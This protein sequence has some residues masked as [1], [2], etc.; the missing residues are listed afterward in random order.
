MMRL[1]HA[2]LAAT[3]IGTT[4]CVFVAGNTGT[5]PQTPTDN[6]LTKARADISAMMQSS[7]HDWTTGNLD[8]FMES[9]E[10]GGAITYVTPARVVHGRDA[11]RALYAPRFA[12]GARQD[13]LSFENMEIDLLTPDVAHVVA[14]YRLSR[15]DST[16]SHGP[17][18]L[19]MRHRDGKWRIIHD[20]S[21]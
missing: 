15:G 21:S 3:V 8:G 7:A 16:T 4:G 14:Y 17:T 5:W 6:Q 2:L 10:P 11:I 20:H 12:S 1:R 9:Y 19:V 18:S 13:S